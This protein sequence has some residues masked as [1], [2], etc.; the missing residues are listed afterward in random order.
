MHKNFDKLGI[1]LTIFKYV[2]MARVC[3]AARL[4]LYKLNSIYSLI[5]SKFC[6]KNPKQLDSV[7]FRVK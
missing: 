4:Q 2:R 7:Q 1:I 3:R 5:D 6:N